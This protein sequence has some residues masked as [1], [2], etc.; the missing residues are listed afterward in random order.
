MSEVVQCYDQ[1]AS[2]LSLMAALARAKEWDRLPELEVQCVSVLER[3][4]VVSPQ[5]TLAP[6]QVAQA[7]R[8][9]ER[10]RAD[11]RAVCE[12]VKPQLAH[13]VATMAGLQKR[14]ELDRA[15]GAPR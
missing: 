13:L 6:A 12:L 14:S 5:E 1:L 4:S 3:L 7:R 11:Q 9:L 2:N 8:L 15:Y 10:I